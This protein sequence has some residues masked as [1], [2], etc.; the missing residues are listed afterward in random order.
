MKQ[1]STLKALMAVLLLGGILTSC[2]NSSSDTTTKDSTVTQPADT[3]SKMMAPD[4][5][6]NPKDT[7][8]K[9][10]QTPPPK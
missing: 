7:S 3:S 10:D 9:G 5:L 2:N 4:T 6:H 1:F 8:H